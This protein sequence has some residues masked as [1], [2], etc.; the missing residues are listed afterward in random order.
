MTCNTH[1]QR[2][3]FVDSPGT[4]IDLTYVIC[5]ENHNKYYFFTD[6]SELKS[7]PLSTFPS[8]KCVI[9]KD[10]HLH[11][12]KNKLKISEDE[13]INTWINMPHVGGVNGD[14]DRHC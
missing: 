8:T 11:V 6:T 10:R 4:A 14:K 12:P 2:N 13:S 3:E 9:C 7:I 5:H 1:R